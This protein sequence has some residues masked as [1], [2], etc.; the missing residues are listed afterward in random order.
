[1]P[2]SD[3]F[4][5]VP[6]SPVWLALGVGLVVAVAGWFAGLLLIGRNRRTHDGG[7]VVAISAATPG[8]TAPLPEL[9]A[10]YLGLLD[11]LGAEHVA[12]ALDARALALRISSLVRAFVTE[13]APAGSADARAMAL[14]DL[15]SADLPCLAGPVADLVGAGYPTA[16]APAAGT[17]PAGLLDAARDVVTAWS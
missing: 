4:A 12:G 6:Y 17:S 10:R 3:F 9:R 8:P 15:R 14:A 5:P 16:F 13:A 11:E 7:G 2:G 1:M